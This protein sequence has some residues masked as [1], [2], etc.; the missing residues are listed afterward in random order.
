VAVRGLGTYLRSNEAREP[1]SRVYPPV[2][3]PDLSL[4][5]C[6]LQLTLLP[7]QRLLGLLQFL[8]ALPAEADLVC[9]VTD[10][11]CRV[12]RALRTRP[13]PLL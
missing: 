13:P 11:L 10:L 5:Q 12:N 1:W 6:S 3:S 8:D 7:F 2:T 4:L 9:K